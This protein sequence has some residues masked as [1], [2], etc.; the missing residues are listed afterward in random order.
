MSR[1]RCGYVYHISTRFRDCSYR[2]EEEGRERR[3]R[4]SWKWCNEFRSG[5]AFVLDVG[6][7][8]KHAMWLPSELSGLFRFLARENGNLYIYSIPD[9]Q[10]VYF[11]KR[12]N[13][14]PD[15]LFDDLTAATEDEGFVL[16]SQFATQPQSI[17][18]ARAAD[19]VSVKTEEASL[20]RG[21]VSRTWTNGCASSGGH[22]N[23][24]DRDG[25]QQGAP[26]AYTPRRRCGFLL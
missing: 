19:P 3:G 5:G 12:S 7:R 2:H 21:S 13:Q 1:Q 25:F 15:T 14:V 23:A 22:G 10:L 9:M 26:S 24:D 11:V 16:P 4:D 8:W 17:D 6:A 20:H 18:T